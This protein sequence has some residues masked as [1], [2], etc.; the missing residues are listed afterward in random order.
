MEPRN[1]EDS[2]KCSDVDHS[3][4]SS[5]KLQASSLIESRGSCYPSTSEA[6]E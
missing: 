3:S 1:E 5:F 2:S 6:G 4:M